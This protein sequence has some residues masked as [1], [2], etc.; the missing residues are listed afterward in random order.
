EMQKH[1]QRLII[2]PHADVYRHADAV[3][4]HY[5]G[6]ASARVSA[7]HWVP[8][9]AT[10]ADQYL[11]TIKDTG[12]YL[13]PITGQSSIIGQRHQDD[14]AAV[15]GLFPAYFTQSRRVDLDAVVTDSIPKWVAMAVANRADE[16]LREIED[17]DI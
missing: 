16:A 9:V 6:K 17:L 2:V 14:L 5:E 12:N 15:E 8:H 11:Q 13:L 7:D 10:W 4:P 1:D 3:E